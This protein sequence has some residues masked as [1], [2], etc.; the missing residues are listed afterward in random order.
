[1]LH[2]CGDCGHLSGP[3]CD[4]ERRLCILECAEQVR[5]PACAL[6]LL[7]CA[8]LCL[9]RD[10]VAPPVSV[11]CDVTY[12]YRFVYF[13]VAVTTTR[14][15]YYFAWYLGEAACVARYG[16]HLPACRCGLGMYKGV[17]VRVRVR[18]RRC[19]GC[20]HVLLV[21]GFGFSGVS[22]ASSGAVV[23]QWDRTC[24]CH[25]LAVETATNMPEITNNWSVMGCDA[26]R[27]MG[28]DAM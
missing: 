23:Y 14:C 15:R 19:I 10:A 11:Q 1:M 20:S 17:R 18:V 22:R 21:S 5:A 25:A 26:L 4:G 24:N 7:C 12:L 3:G 16:Q 2:R 8:V 6:R 28:C 13:W 27:W 9:M